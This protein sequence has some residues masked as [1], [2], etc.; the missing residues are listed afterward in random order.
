MSSI[1]VNNFYTPSYP[2]LRKRQFVSIAGKSSDTTDSGIGLEE[3][4]KGLT[5]PLAI[6]FD[7]IIVNAWAAPQSVS[8][9]TNNGWQ[10]DATKIAHSGDTIALYSVNIALFGKDRTIDGIGM[11]A[12]GT[13]LSNKYPFP[14]AK[15]GSSITYYT[16][17]VFD[18]V[19]GGWADQGE[20]LLLYKD[21]KGYELNLLF[22]YSSYACFVH[23][24]D[25]I[26][27]KS[28]LRKIFDNPDKLVINSVRFDNYFNGAFYNNYD[29]NKLNNQLKEVADTW[30]DVQIDKHF[31]Y[32]LNLPVSI[33]MNWLSNKILAPASP[34]PSTYTGPTQYIYDFVPIKVAKDA[35]PIE[36]TKFKTDSSISA[37]VYVGF[38]SLF[39]NTHAA[40]TSKYP[41]GVVLYRHVGITT[42]T[43]TNILEYM[44][45][46]YIPSSDNSST[47][48]TGDID[49]II[50]LSNGKVIKSGFTAHKS[51]NSERNFVYIRIPDGEPSF[52]LDGLMM[53]MADGPVSA[54]MMSLN[55]DSVVCDTITIYGKD[56]GEY[57]LDMPSD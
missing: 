2:Y 9:S 48:I 11:V 19:P 40:T 13:R 16:I 45:P 28:I 47:A 10:A 30:L 34:D 24:L 4:E 57:I 12:C 38:V 26:F 1:V 39:Y 25:D 21:G 17:K 31:G 50:R 55:P 15:D 22:K 14:T 46:V 42:A 33:S 18:D 44:Y 29:A 56:M 8:D 43:P 41:V 23:N 3:V 35:T 27:A 7:N 51:D 20:Q 54:Y 5:E 49:V 32:A 6:D 37:G 53:N 36:G 52:Y